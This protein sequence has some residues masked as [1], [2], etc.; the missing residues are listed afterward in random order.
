MIVDNVL[1]LDQQS[2]GALRLEIRQWVCRT[3]IGMDTFGSLV[4]NR[5]LPPSIALILGSDE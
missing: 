2:T 5:R 3:V 4:R 1:L